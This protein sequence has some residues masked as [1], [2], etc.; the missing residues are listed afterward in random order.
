MLKYKTI[1]G[2]KMRE[3][4]DDFLDYLL[5]TSKLISDEKQSLLVEGLSA[6]QN[7]HQYVNEVEFWKWMHQN[8]YK[9]DLFSSPQAIANYISQGSGKANWLKLQLQGKGY[10]WDWMAS[11]K[12]K[13]SNLF[14]KL[15]AGVDPTQAGIDVTN[16]NLLTNKSTKFQH[17]SYL[18]KGKVNTQVL[19]NTPKDTVVITQAENTAL[20]NQIGY[21]SKSF[22]TKGESVAIRDKRFEQA[23]NG[24]AKTNY[25]LSGVSSVMLK[26]GIVSATFA[27]TIEGFASYRDYKSGRLSKSQ[28]LAEIAKSGANTGITGAA[29]AGIMVPI[30][31]VIVTAG[32]STL[33]TFPISIIVA[34]GIEKIVAPMFKKGQYAEVIAQMTFY[35]D[36]GNGYMNFIEQCEQSFAHFGGYLDR[37]MNQEQK[38]QQLKQIDQHLNLKLIN[39]LDKI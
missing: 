37:I 23:K 25:T 14:S 16:V 17:K 10:E 5:E 19:K 18:S 4:Q 2:R 1:G 31:S 30:Q 34:S 9:K 28:Y 3:E 33:V 6:Y 32:V 39:A 24:L 26:A 27:A 22:Q 36:I 15:D 7:S 20:P 38:Y 12:A 21:K 8:Y 13:V 11:E 35:E 29:T